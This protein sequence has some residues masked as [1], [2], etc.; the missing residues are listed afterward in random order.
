[1]A[2]SPEG[3]HGR[4]TMNRRRLTTVEDRAAVAAKP[5]RPKAHGGVLDARLCSVVLL[6][7]EQEILASRGAAAP[8]PVYLPRGEHV[9]NARPLCFAP[10][11]VSTAGRK[12]YVHANIVAKLTSSVGACSRSRRQDRRTPGVKVMA[13][14]NRARRTRTP[15][16]VSDQAKLTRGAGTRSF[17]KT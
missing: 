12:N 15:R 16:R 1:M 8:A 3:F 9:V 7:T 14:D 5:S 2:A 13:A 10:P 4:R 11:V 17:Q 6:S